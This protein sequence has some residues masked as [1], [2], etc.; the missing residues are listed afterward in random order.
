MC[1]TVKHSFL[2]DD[3]LSVFKQPNLTKKQSQRIL[4]SVPSNFLGLINQ[5]TA[6]QLELHP[7]MY[8]GE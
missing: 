2:I 7:F 3:L 1:E 6:K 8:H 4:P 5:Y